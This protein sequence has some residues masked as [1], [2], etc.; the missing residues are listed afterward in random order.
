MLQ[1]GSPC[2]FH[3]QNAYEWMKW[4]CGFSFIQINE[5]NLRMFV[6]TNALWNYFL[7]INGFFNG[8][9]LQIELNSYNAHLWMV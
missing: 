4:L 7:L 2:K 5:Q 9:M 3:N 8:I 6:V 1:L